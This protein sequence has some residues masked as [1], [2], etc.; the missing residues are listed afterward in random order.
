[1]IFVAWQFNAIEPIYLQIADRLMGQ[2]IRGVYGC[3]DRL[4]SVRELAL[5]AEV[6]PNT[7][8]RAFMEL[9]NKGLVVTE[10]TAGKFV[11]KNE[12]TIREIKGA[13]LAA[14]TETFLN[15]LNSY[16]ITKEQLIIYL[17]GGKTDG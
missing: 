7:I 11:T 9:Q 17:K 12:E 6:N 2:I 14:K 13:L 1:M 10:S 5:S 8:Q 3:G 4:P 16:G 15:S